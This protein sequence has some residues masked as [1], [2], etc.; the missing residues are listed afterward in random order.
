[1]DIR[2]IY[3]YALQREYEGKR[4]FEENA[5]RLGHA[6]AVSAFKELAAE[7]QKHIEFIQSQLSGIDKG[8][9]SSDAFA[10]DMEAAG[11]FLQRAQTEMLDQ[12]VLEAMVPDLP[13][14]RTAYLIEMD[15]ANYYQNASKQATGEAKKVLKLLAKWERGHEALFKTLHDKAYEVYSQ[16]PWG[17]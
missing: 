13:V 16:M 8:P 11:F 10:K 5:Q 9:I 6:A 2:K 12:T 3:E 17:G 1:M 15:F 7:E 14:L 4:F